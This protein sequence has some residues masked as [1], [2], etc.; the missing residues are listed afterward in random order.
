[1]QK[2]YEALLDR[3]EELHGEVLKSLDELSPEAF[4]WKPEADMNSLSVLIAHLSG[5]ERFWVGDVARGE[6]SQRDREAEFRVNGL[7]RESLQQRIRDLED[8]E[9]VAFQKMGLSE[10]EEIRRLE[11]GRQY[12]VAW[13]LTHALEHTAI[14][15]GHIQILSQLW[16]QKGQT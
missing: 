11:D 5:A 3:F 12:S 2:F 1:M 16:K 8:Y 6:P 14:H 4:D 15:V 10:L 13:A 9:K 7:S